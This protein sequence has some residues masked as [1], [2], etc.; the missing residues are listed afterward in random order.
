MSQ[1]NCYDENR[2]FGN[3]HIPTSGS[4]ASKKVFHSVLVRSCVWVEQENSVL[5]SSSPTVKEFLK[6]FL[7]RR[8]HTDNRNVM[9]MAFNVSPLQVSMFRWKHCRVHKTCGATCCDV[10]STYLSA[11]SSGWARCLLKGLSENSCCENS[12]IFGAET[13]SPLVSAYELNMLVNSNCL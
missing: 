8:T 5:H 6:S 7:Y 13:S 3:L 9:R 4:T 1:K 2:L 11:N 10:A 12:V